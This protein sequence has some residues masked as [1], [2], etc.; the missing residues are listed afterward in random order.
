MFQ[1]D[2]VTL[3]ELSIGFWC[4]VVG[5][6]ALLSVYFLLIRF[7]KKKHFFH[8]SISTFFL[9]LAIGRIF[10]IIHDF[11]TL[12]PVTYSLFWRLGLFFQWLSLGTF[13][14]TTGVIILRNKMETKSYWWKFVRNSWIKLAAI[15]APLLLR[16]TLSVS[17]SNPLLR[18]ISSQLRPSRYRL[19]MDLRI[20]KSTF[21]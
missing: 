12:I 21:L 8:L 10:L 13:S 11:F 15:F 14:V 18:D 19:N 3:R 20:P 9:F 16:W 17:N 1:I 7:R 2:S 6:Y 5:Y 4:T